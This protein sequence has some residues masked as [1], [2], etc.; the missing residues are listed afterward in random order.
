M[1]SPLL[2]YFNGRIK[3]TTQG[4]VSIVNGRPVV[5]GGTTYVVKCYIKRIQYTGVTSGSRPLPL[6]SQLEG[7]MLPGA[8]GDSFY[9]RGFA[10]QKAPLGDG[11]WLGDLSGLTFTDITAQESFLLPGGEV[12]FKFG[13]ET[14]MVAT[15]QRSSGV[16]GGE[17]IDEILYP[18]LGGVEIQL[19]GAEVQT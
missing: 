6:E 18:A 19:T 10:L 7:R 2:P 1:A 8:S 11:N 12:E 14:E 4:T 17:G 9:Y 13:N 15:I 16:F 5:S 3:A